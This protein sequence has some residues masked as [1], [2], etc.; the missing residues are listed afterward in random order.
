MLLHTS[1]W[2]LIIY[3]I[4]R[5]LPKLR[6]LRS[7]LQ[8]TEKALPH[9]LRKLAN[10]TVTIQDC[11]HLQYEGPYLY[12]KL[13]YK[14]SIK[15]H[16]KYCSTISASA[17]R[18][19]SIISVKIP[20]L[21]WTKYITELEVNGQKQWIQFCGKNLATA[22]EANKDARWHICRYHFLLIESFPSLNLLYFW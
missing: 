20:N 21:N 9:Q 8:L 11:K 13:G 5:R 14:C 7:G 12:N 18:S 19:A 22:E 6:Q 3:L 16:S 1:S 17:Y 15:Q 10:R 2:S 4:L